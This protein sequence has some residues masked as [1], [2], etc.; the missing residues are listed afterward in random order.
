MSYDG[1]NRTLQAPFKLTP[2][3]A[4]LIS[5][6]G[7]LKDDTIKIVSKVEVNEQEGFQTVSYV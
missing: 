4:S 7:F 2:D 1:K 6:S 3:P 5:Q